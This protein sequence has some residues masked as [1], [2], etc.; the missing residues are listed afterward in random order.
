MFTCIKAGSGTEG[1]ELPK[2]YK[3][4]DKSNNDNIIHKD[5]YCISK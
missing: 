2:T 1:V 3:K 5:S 4:K